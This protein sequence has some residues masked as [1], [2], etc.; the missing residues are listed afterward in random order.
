MIVGVPFGVVLIMGVATVGVAFELTSFGGVVT[1]GV[2]F[3]GALLGLAGAT[4][5]GVISGGV[6]GTKMKQ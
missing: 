1:V 2:V 3:E 6:N 5:V 4:F